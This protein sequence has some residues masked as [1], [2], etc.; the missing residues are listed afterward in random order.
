MSTPGT[1]VTSLLKDRKFIA[2][3]FVVILA[4]AFYFDLPSYFSFEGLRENE[5]ALRSFAS[6]NLVL[7]VVTYILA[8]VIVVTFSLPGALWLTLGGGLV[9]G[10]LWGGFYAVSGATLGA[11][12]L[13]LLARYIVGDSLRN[14]Y[15]PKLA[16]FEAGFRKNAVYFMLSLRLLPVFPFFLVN[17]AA[18]LL[19][20]RGSTFALTTFFG[21]MP[22][23]F[24]FA[25]IGNGISVAL[26][27]GETP[28][29]SLASRPEILLPLIGLGLLTL[30]PALLGK[31]LGLKASSIEEGEQ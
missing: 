7:S 27:D 10:P 5:A 9:F 31:R 26:R 20:V 12:C 15:G 6:N 22:G 18:A 24:V 19:G 3:L 13:F 4:L 11:I 14:R 8:Y 29:L 16:T 28:N 17:L 2:A 1:N 21:I 25:S 23:T 30:L